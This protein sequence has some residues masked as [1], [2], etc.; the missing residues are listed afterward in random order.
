MPD[1][2]SWLRESIVETGKKWGNEF[3]DCSISGVPGNLCVTPLKNTDGIRLVT[4][5]WDGY[6]PLLSWKSFWVKILLGDSKVDVEIP[7]SYK[8][9]DGHSITADIPLNQD[10]V[11]ADTRIPNTLFNLS[12]PLTKQSTH[13]IRK[14]IENI[15][16]ITNTVQCDSTYL[17][18]EDIAGQREVEASGIPGFVEAYNLI[19]PGS[20]KADLLRYYLLYKY[21]G[22]YIDSKSLL[23]KPL[24][25]KIFH[26]LMNSDF[27]V[28]YNNTV[29]I[30]FMGARE[31]SPIMLMALQKA[32][33]NILNRD[34]TSHELGITGNRVLNSIVSVSSTQDLSPL[35]WKGQVV[36]K[37]TKQHGENV[38]FMKIAPSDEKIYYGEE[39]LWVR[40][41][42][43]PPDR[44]TPKNY[45]KDLWIRREVFTDGNPVS[46]R[47]FPSGHARR[48]IFAYA[49]TILGILIFAFV[50]LRYGQIKWT[51]TRQ[52]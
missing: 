14:N 25:S 36:G 42:I 48:D 2:P 17:I 26:D 19:R 22:V 13:R 21:G 27:F 50:V 32:I 44:V 10:R 4:H 3:L 45:Y 1:F 7:H 8:I 6:S 43:L 33:T 40:Q 35:I 16:E 51:V 41:G 20:Y 24:S 15:R 23:L 37:R 47:F 34:Y 39:L 18:I 12:A 5:R 29:E 9:P 38:S 49:M 28:G 46:I 31:G 52:F 30:S 11:V